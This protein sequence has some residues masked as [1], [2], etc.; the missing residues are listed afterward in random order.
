MKYDMEK[1]SNSEKFKLLIGKDMWHTNDLDGKLPTVFVSDGPHGVKKRPDGICEPAT[2]L[3][4]LVNLANTWN[5]E[6]AYL[7]GKVIADECVE[8]QVDVILA[9]GVNIKRTP[10]CGRNFEYFSEDPYLSG[11]M[12]KAYIKGVQDKGVGTSLKHFAMNNGEFERMSRS[13][14]ADERTIREIYLRAFEIA[15]ESN[16]WTVMCS[17][18]AVNGIL[19]SENKWILSDVLKG[20]FGYDGAIISDWGAVKTPYKSIKAGLDVIMPF[21]DSAQSDLEYAYNNGWIVDEEIDAS[22]LRVLNLIEK[23]ENSKSLRKVEMTKAERH[24]IAEDIARESF[25]LLKNDGALPIN[26][27]KVLVVGEL[28]KEPI[29]G[30]GGSAKVVGDYRPENLVDMLNKAC[31]D[32]EFIYPRVRATDVHSRNLGFAIEQAYEADAVILLVNGKDEREEIDREDIKLS[33]VQEKRIIDFASV[34]PNTIVC[35][36]AGSAIDMSNWIDKVKSVVFV[37]YAGEGVHTALADVLTG[38]VSPSGKLTETFPLSIT[39]LPTND[40]LSNYHVDRYTEGVFVGYRY[41]DTVSKPVLFPFG[42]GLSY[43]D[44]TYSNLRVKKCGET[45][46]VVSYSITNNSTIDAKEVSQ[47]YVKDLFSNVSKPAKE[48]KEFSKDFIKA[49]QT[50]RV[51]KNLDYCSFAYYSLP[52]KKWQ[53][54][55]GDYEIL[56]GSS[57][58]D[59]R[60][61]QKVNIERGEETQNSLCLKNRVHK[62]KN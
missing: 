59:I 48:L 8:K 40:T 55:N 12:A 30:G 60:L 43:A 62:Y 10:I 5:E 19:A 15:L 53:V 9:P 57:S 44:F 29:I 45:E 46:F 47:I 3:P 16:P 23:N 51:K 4:T 2:T 24:A 18:N 38:K 17:Y 49:G 32:A 1:L 36:Y 6:L 42:H 27:G 11:R 21:D 7:D 52:L 34:N 13:S 37:G 14:E 35:V 26:K 41:Y 50:V 54:D 61:K 33:A 58:R 31:A 39:D 28:A 22:V 25:V 56:I 20:E